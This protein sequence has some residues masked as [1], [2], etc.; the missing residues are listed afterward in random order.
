MIYLDTNIVIRFIEGI[1]IHQRAIHTRLALFDEVPQSLLTSRLTHMECQVLPLR[2]HDVGLLDRY[3]RFFT[4]TEIVLQEVDAI[5]LDKAARIRAVWRF[6]TPD[7]IHL[8]TAIVQG[9]MAFLTGD[10]QLARCT[11]IPVEVL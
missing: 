9:A 4:R 2:N 8:A 3:D 5:V 6:K 7:A 10:A 11:E 1:P